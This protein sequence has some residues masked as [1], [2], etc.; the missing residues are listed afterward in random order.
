MTETRARRSH[1]DLGNIFFSAK[2]YVSNTHGIS[3]MF[4]SSLYTSP[5]LTPTMQW[6]RS[7]ISTVATPNVSVS[8]GE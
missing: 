1:Y 5:A 2:Y 6:L 4:K 7:D 3:D 8:S